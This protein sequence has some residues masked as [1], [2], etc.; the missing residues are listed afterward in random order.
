MEGTITFRVAKGE[1][2]S[3][4][5]WGEAA[6]LRACTKLE[7]ISTIQTEGDKK[8]EGRI[9]LHLALGRQEIIR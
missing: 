2:T 1:Q 3:V 4:Q 7:G 5:G 9:T 8:T 6:V